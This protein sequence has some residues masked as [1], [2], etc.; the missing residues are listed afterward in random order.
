[1]FSNL[2]NLILGLFDIKTSRL[3][4][5]I[6]VLHILCFIDILKNYFYSLKL[7][8]NNKCE[9]NYFFLPII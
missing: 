1:M 5:K 2:I 3:Y 9:K 7:K 6:F 4:Y 8:L